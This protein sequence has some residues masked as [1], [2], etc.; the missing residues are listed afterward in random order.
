M[1]TSE[2]IPLPL[3]EGVGGGQAALEV[4]HI[5]SRSRPTPGPSRKR[6]GSKT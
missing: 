1:L 5:P 3:A 2:A 6:E 4:A